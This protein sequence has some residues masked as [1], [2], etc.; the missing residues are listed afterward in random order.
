MA[1]VSKYRYLLNQY[2]ETVQ[3]EQFRIICHISKRTARYLL[4]S[5]LVPCVQSGKK[6]RNYT[7]KMKDIVRY[8]EGYSLCKKIK[9][10]MLK[11]FCHL[12]DEE[13]IFRFYVGG[14]LGVD[15]WA[16]EQLLYLKEQPG[17]QDIE[18]IVALPF[19]GHD[20][21]WDAMSKQRLQ[22]IIHNAT[23]CIVIGQSGTTSDY[24]KRNYYMVDHAD[25]L[26]AVYDNNRKLR[27]GTG[28]T[29]N[30]ALKQNLRIIFLHPD[31]AEIS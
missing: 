22:I 29:V 12:H 13:G 14:T 1:Q 8:N 30:Y 9:K 10:A 17:Y 25:F 3:K 4:Q 31:T 2:P 26:L 19:E 7:I 18:L 28:Q 11:T 5:G 20:S 6:T 21:K 15:M 24:K 23:K 16:A 27:S